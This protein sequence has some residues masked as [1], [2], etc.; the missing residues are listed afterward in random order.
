VSRFWISSIA[1]M[2]AKMMMTTSRLER[3]GS[4]TTDKIADRSPPVTSETLGILA[5]ITVTGDRI[6]RNATIAAIVVGGLL[7]TGRCGLV[8]VLI[9]TM[10][11]VRRRTPI[12]DDCLEFDRLSSLTHADHPNLKTLLFIVL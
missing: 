12:F 9:R 10:N 11:R 3:S 5:E 8:G 6:D 7:R 4:R 2:T 1:M